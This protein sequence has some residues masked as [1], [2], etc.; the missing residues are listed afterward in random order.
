MASFR[1]SIT[2]GLLISPPAFC[3]SN[4]RLGV[5]ELSLSSSVVMTAARLFLVSCTRRISFCSLAKCLAKSSSDIAS[6]SSD[7]GDIGDDVDEEAVEVD[8]GDSDSDEKVSRRG[9][10]CVDDEMFSDANDSDSG[11]SVRSVSSNPNCFNNM[12]SETT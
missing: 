5:G 10:D 6:G 11:T 12:Q 9:V 8:G 4:L 1:M 7:D 2:S 3:R